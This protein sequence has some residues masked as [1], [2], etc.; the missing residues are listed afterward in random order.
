M[1]PGSA[2]N[3]TVKNFTYL[4][5][6]VLFVFQSDR[7]EYNGGHFYWECNDGQEQDCNT[8]IGSV[9]SGGKPLLLTV[10]WTIEATNIVECRTST[11]GNQ[12]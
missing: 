4:N 7:I 3:K 1:V 2:Y 11:F 9:N 6:E 12:V 5:C 10:V 8:D